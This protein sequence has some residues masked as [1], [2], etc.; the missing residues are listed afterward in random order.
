MAVEPFYRSAK[1]LV[2]P[3]G[4]NIHDRDCLGKLCTKMEKN[5]RIVIPEYYL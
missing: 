3:L 4:T 5:A 2:K 1:N